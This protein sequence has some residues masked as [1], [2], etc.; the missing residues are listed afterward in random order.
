[1]KNSAWMAGFAERVWF[2]GSWTPWVRGVVLLTLLL[3]MPAV[4][5]TCFDEPFVLVVPG[6]LARTSAFDTSTAGANKRGGMLSKF[7]VRS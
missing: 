4:I 1:M 7:R 2:G 6:S 3:T 5:L